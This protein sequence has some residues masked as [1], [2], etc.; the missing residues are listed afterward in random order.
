MLQVKLGDCCPL[1]WLNRLL[2]LKMGMK[3]K[4]YR[5][6]TRV[7]H[8]NKKGWGGIMRLIHIHLQLHGTC[9]EGVMQ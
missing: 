7:K 4:F 1:C 3:M 6:V 5:Q 8:F 2:G 9:E